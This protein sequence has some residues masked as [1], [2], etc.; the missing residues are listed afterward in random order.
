MI[1][2]TGLIFLPR[3]PEE[4]DMLVEEVCKKYSFTEKEHAAAVISVAIR[5]IDNNTA[6]TTLEYLGHSVWKNIANQV[7]NAK[8][9]AI[10][11]TT[12]V[13]TLL[14]MLKHNPADQQARDELERAAG[15]GSKVAR[16]ALDSLDPIPLSIPTGTE[17]N[18]VQ[19]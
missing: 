7:A 1:A 8:S 13:N 6:T 17:S 3:S 15:E 9:S 18:G 4:F 19:H 5:H 2:E 16:A 14:D 11:H 10:Q 12:Q